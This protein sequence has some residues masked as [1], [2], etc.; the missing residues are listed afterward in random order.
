MLST[1][2]KGTTKNRRAM[3]AILSGAAALGIVAA[4]ALPAAAMNFAPLT[5]CPGQLVA[6]AH[7]TGSMGVVQIGVQGMSGQGRFQTRVSHPP[8]VFSFQA[9]IGGAGYGFAF[10][11][12]GNYTVTGGSTQCGA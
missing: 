8:A 6:V 2:Q 4:S 12:S 5:S 3:R 7:V 10:V 9:P 11:D 1:N